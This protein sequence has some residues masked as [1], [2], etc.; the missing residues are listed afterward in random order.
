MLFWHRTGYPI[1]YQLHGLFSTRVYGGI[2][3]ITQ[4]KYR[5]LLRAKLT[6]TLLRRISPWPCKNNC[7]RVL[8]TSDIH[9]IKIIPMMSVGVICKFLWRS[10]CYVQVS[11]VA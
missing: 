10:F 3:I 2:S 1:V 11:H 6:K 9:E 4:L 5:Q 8:K 7:V